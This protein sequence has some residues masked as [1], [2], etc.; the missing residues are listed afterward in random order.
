MADTK[1]SYEFERAIFMSNPK[2]HFQLMLNAK[3]NLLMLPGLLIS[4]LAYK[5]MNIQTFKLFELAMLT[6]SDCN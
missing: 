2:F 1:S 4:V 6:V 5:I 3:D